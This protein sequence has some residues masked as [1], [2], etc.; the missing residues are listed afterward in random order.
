MACG[1][2]GVEARFL[3][4]M[5]GLDAFGVAAELEKCIFRHRGE[6]LNGRDKDFSAM[7]RTLQEHCER[8]MTVRRD[9]YRQIFGFCL[10]IR[11]LKHLLLQ[12]VVGMVCSYI[13]I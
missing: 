9:A 4:G 7:L 8:F 13:K 6:F 3:E 2:Q 11:R 12:D 1:V 10:T 5:F